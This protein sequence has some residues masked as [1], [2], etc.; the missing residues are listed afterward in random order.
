MLKSVEF[1]GFNLGVQG[2]EPGQSERAFILKKVLK[3]KKQQNVEISRFYCV[4][5]QGAIFAHLTKEP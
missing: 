3:T 1:T 5:D 2:S 4:S